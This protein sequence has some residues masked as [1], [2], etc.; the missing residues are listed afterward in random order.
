MCGLI[1]L[2]PC[3]W[4]LVSDSRVWMCVCEWAYCDQRD[5]KGACFGIF[6][7]D[8]VPRGLILTNQTL[9]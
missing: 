7:D 6:T 4:L 5:Q 3:S 9:L 1:I 8:K 2:Q